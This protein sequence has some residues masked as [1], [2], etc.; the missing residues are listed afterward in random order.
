ML[1]LAGCSK[2]VVIKPDPNMTAPVDKHEVL[3]GD[4]V[5]DMAQKFEWNKLSIDEANKRFEKM[6]E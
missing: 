5:R 3:E 6:R 2:T 1:V 4:T